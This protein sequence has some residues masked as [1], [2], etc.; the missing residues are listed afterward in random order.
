MSEREDGIL[1]DEEQMKVL[2][3]I[4]TDVESEARA[5]IEAISVYHYL[6]GEIKKVEPITFT[7]TVM[8]TTGDVQYATD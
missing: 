5:K 1:S 6:F 2:V 8:P 4:I 7:I 3:S